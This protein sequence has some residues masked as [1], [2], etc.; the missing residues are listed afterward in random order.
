MTN[1]CKLLSDSGEV[2][3]RGRE[4]AATQ[5]LPPPVVSMH[6]R[7]GPD[8]RRY[9]DPHFPEVA[10]IFTSADGAVDAPR[11]IVVY[12]YSN[13]LKT[14]K[15]L[16]LLTLTLC[17]IPSYPSGELGWSINLSH[18]AEHA[19]EHRNMVTLLQYYT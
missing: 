6:I 10:A 14:I 12:P 4:S 16:S 11:N 17:H 15:S 13:R 2:E 19:T 7:T 9:N 3:R 8:R 5:N 1:Q 18:V